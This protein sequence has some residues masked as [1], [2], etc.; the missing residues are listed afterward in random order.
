MNSPYVEIT[1]EH[2][3]YHIH[4]GWMAPQGVITRWQR[5]RWAARS[6]VRRDNV[7]TLYPEHNKAA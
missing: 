4:R 2:G 6:Q 1:T 7:V 5:L 3:T